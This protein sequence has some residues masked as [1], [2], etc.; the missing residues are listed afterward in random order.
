MISSKFEGF[1]KTELE[2]SRKLGK[3]NGRVQ[4]VEQRARGCTATA[5]AEAR[6]RT[7]KFGSSSSR[8]NLNLKDTYAQTIVNKRPGGL[9]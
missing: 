3:Q 1:M 4:R 7:R 2:E 9:I 8:D 5:S 6:T